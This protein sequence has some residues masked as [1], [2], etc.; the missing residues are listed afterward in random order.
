MPEPS[1]QI[2]TCTD[3]LPTHGE[4]SPG[5]NDIHGDGAMVVRP[6]SPGKLSSSVCDFI[7][8]HSFWGTWGTWERIK[9]SELDQYAQMFK[10]MTSCF[11]GIL[12]HSIIYSSTQIYQIHCEYVHMP[13]LCRAL[14]LQTTMRDFFSFLHL[15]K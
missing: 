13:E 2:D 11:N 3:C 4:W 14:K 8:G 10:E 12:A 7:N 5:L 15:T 6:R 9:P 1:F